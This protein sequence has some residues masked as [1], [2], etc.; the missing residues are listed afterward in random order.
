MQ[1]RITK[2]G[3]NYT[4]V[5]DYYLPNLNLTEEHRPIGKWG[6]LYRKYLEEHHPI[7]YNCLVLSGR[8]WT[9]LADLNEHA[10]NR[11]GCLVERLRASEGITEDLKEADPM[12]W[13]RGMNSIQNRAEEIV[14]CELIYEEDVR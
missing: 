7:R 9:V 2:N 10:Q 11:M 4:L 13:V 1:N 3:L 5:G 6:R 8:L 12:A 14:L